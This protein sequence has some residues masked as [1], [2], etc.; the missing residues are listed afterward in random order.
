MSNN[1]LVKNIG[2]LINEISDN[3]FSKVNA[4]IGVDGFVD[5]IIHVVDKR[6]NAEKYS[7]L[8]KIDELGTKILKA[9]GLSANIELVPKQIK[10]GGNGP[11]LANALVEYGNR[12]TYIGA[13]GDGDVH[14]VF[15]DMVYR[16]ENIISIANPGHTDAIEFEDGKLMLGKLESLKDINWDNIKNKIKLDKLASLLD[17]T[18]LLGLENWTMVPYMNTIWEGMINEVFPLMNREDR[19]GI[20]FFDLADPEKR[21]DEDIIEA[22]NL[23]AK[24]EEKFKVILGLNLKEAIEISE[25]LGLEI[26]KIDG[27]Y[28]LK[29]LTR[30]VAKELNIYCLVVHPVDKA[31]AFCNGE[32]YET[33]GPYTAKPMLTTGAGDNFNAG[34]CLA[35]S[36]GLPVQISLVMGTATSGYYVRNAKSPNKEALLEFLNDWKV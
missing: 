24:F 25:V 12:V 10:L 32:Y 2:Q 35:Q 22:L 7:R 33:P 36:L 28:E 13:L 21:T 5:E 23:L 6:E 9:A 20:A 30:K 4:V 27:A 29:D 26:N 17:E 15:K 11:I 1:E 34:F 31:S 16:C 18:D 3:D 8:K 14:S 19:G